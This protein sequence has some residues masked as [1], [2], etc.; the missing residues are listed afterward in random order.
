MSPINEYENW[1]TVIYMFHCYEL[2]SLR[3]E[4]HRVML[5]TAI[6]LGQ[7]DRSR[8]NNTGNITSL[9][10]LFSDALSASVSSLLVMIL[11]LVVYQDIKFERWIDK[12]CSFSD[13]YHTIPTSDIKLNKKKETSIR[14]CDIKCL[15]GI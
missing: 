4:N 6:L 2:L 10:E 3:Q 1:A 12:H 15:T 8:T 11:M 14:S 5:S 7:E 13:I 9:M